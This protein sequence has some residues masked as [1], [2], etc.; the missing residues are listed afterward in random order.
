MSVGRAATRVAAV[1]VPLV[2]LIALVAGPAAADDGKVRLRTSSSFTAGGSSGAVSVTLSR[3]GDGCI[4]PRTSLVIRMSG[5]TAEQVRVDVARLGGW[6][7]LGVRQA[8][9]GE[10]DVPPVGPEREALCRGGSLTRFRVAFAATVPSGRVTFVAAVSSR[11]GVLDEQSETRRVVNRGIAPTPTR[12]TPSPTPTPSP[13]VD[14][15]EPAAAATTAPT[16]APAA[17]GNSSTGG[18][19]GVFGVTVML[20]G[21]VMV[22]LGVA[23]LVFLIRRSR[24]EPRYA[25][26]PGHPGDPTLILPIIRD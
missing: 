19:P 1:L 25:A 5:L 24:R 22:G 23:I 12:S 10:V 13:T 8:G 15:T 16:V 21:A 26:G 3:H 6:Q 4:A 18:G 11:G 17:V 7:P 2:G 20:G 9:E 14:E